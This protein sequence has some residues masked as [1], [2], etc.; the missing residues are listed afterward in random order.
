MAPSLLAS[1]NLF[2]YRVDQYGLLGVRA[3]NQEGVG[4]AGLIKQLPEDHTI[5]NCKQN[6]T[7]RENL[8]NAM[9]HLLGAAAHIRY[10]HNLFTAQCSVG[11]TVA[12]GTAVRHLGFCL[13]FDS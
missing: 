3:G 6:N 13:W 5:D 4:A 12:G 2:I 7:T 10:G 11:E 9:L 1:T 8:S